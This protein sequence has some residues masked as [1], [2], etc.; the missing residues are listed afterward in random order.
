MQH[1]SRLLEDFCGRQLRLEGVKRKRSDIGA[2]FLGIRLRCKDDSAPSLLQTAIDMN[3]SPDDADGEQVVSTPVD[4]EYDGVDDSYQ[5]NIKEQLHQDTDNAERT[6]DKL[7]PDSDDPD[8]VDGHFQHVNDKVSHQKSSTGH[9]KEQHLDMDQ[10]TKCPSD[11]SSSSNLND[12]STVTPAETAYTTDGPRQTS[13]FQDTAINPCPKCGCRRFT[14]KFPDRLCTGCGGKVP[15]GQNT[16][17]SP[18]R[19]QYL[20]EPASTD[21]QVGGTYA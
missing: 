16:I 11:S 9:E 3:S 8:G 17:P 1:F 5:N 21:D 4:D 19:G 20:S 12:I 13:L 2:H 7:A 10:R 6:D 18:E 15:P 14:G